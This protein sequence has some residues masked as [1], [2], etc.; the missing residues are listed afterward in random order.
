MQWEG[1]ILVLISMVGVIGVAGIVGKG[2]QIPAVAHISLLILIANLMVIVFFLRSS[3]KL[4]Q[5]E[6]IIL[7]LISM[8]RYYID[9]I[10]V[11]R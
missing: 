3:W 9:F 8:V 4:V 11:G 6:G 7:V 2:I 1:I 5:W 10:V